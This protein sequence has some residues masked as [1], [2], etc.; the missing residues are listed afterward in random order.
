MP[1]WHGQ[2]LKH[3]AWPQQFK[4]T[5]LSVLMRFA[6]KVRLKFP[7]NS[8][9]LHCFGCLNSCSC[10]TAAKA[11]ENEGKLSSCLS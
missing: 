7:P 8:G 2:A 6:D 1:C 4:M 9:R 5:G 11:Q 3:T 10:L